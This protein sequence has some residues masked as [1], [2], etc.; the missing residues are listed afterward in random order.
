MD[1]VQLRAWWWR[2]QGLD[3]S[4]AGAPPAS[5]L[6][7]AG[8]ARS[9][10]GASPYLSI[11]ARSGTSRANIDRAAAALEIHELPAARN[12]TYVVPRSD[13]ALA[14][15]VGQGFI[16]ADLNVGRKLGVTDREIEK[17][18]ASVMENLAD[19]PL[20][21]DQ[22]RDGVGGAVRNL[23]EPG[24]KKGLTTTLPLA[25]SKLQAWG[26]IRRVPNNGRLDQQR[27]GYV[28]WRPNPL[29]KFK[30]SAEEAY[31]ELARRY[32]G[33]IAPAS[34]AEFQWFSGLGAKAAKAAIEPL[35]LAPLEPGSDRLLHRGD[36]DKLAA[37]KIP[38]DHDYALIG[39]LDSLVL[40]R[41]DLERLLD[42][43]DLRRSVPAEKGH[44]VLGGLAD[45][46]SHAIADRGRVVGL[47]EY[48]TE[49]ADIAWSAFVPKNDRLKKAVAKMEAFI[50]D[51]LGDARSFSLDSPKSRAPRIA[52]LRA[53]TG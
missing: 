51:D 29:A 41:R 28:R 16:E 33:W 23:G 42:P 2:L 31:T 14:L 22:I 13:F 40:L 53:A 7:R 36:R 19:K 50:R 47:W 3:G 8:W 18:C 20:S 37:L 24:K 9:V 32:F 5:V 6:E 49:A 34:V 30:L 26:E 4:L 44:A 11:F 12:C 17:L 43:V 35:E 25:L 1:C 21:P 46:P 39:S 27:Y 45:L 10:G 48:D 52:A 38:K 15:K